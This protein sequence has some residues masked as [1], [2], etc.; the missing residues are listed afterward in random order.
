MVL[1]IKLI[2]CD[3]T[4]VKS[5]VV[6]Y[7]CIVRPLSICLQPAVRFVYAIYWERAV[8]L[9]FRLC[10]CILDDVHGTCVPSRKVSWAGCEI[11]LY[12]SLIIAFF[13]YLVKVERFITFISEHGGFQR[14][15]KS[16]EI[17]LLLCGI[18]QIPAI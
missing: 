10:C 8:L 18:V 14:K 1:C 17:C 12:P 2:F 6:N 13:M 7:D 4:R 11:R 15:K 3:C 5:A 9:A 16:W